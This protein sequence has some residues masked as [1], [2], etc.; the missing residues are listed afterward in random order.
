MTFDEVGEEVVLLPSIESFI[1]RRLQHAEVRLA[2]GALFDAMNLR[3]LA[4]CGF[5]ERATHRPRIVLMRVQI[6]AAQVFEPHAELVFVEGIDLRHVHALGG[7]T[8]RG[9][10]ELRIIP[11][12]HGIDHEHH[13]GMTLHIPLQAEEA[14]VRAALGDGLDLTRQVGERGELLLREDEKGFVFGEHRRRDEE[15]RMTDEL[16]V[17][18]LV[19]A[20]G[21]DVGTNDAA[22]QLRPRG[23]IRLRPQ[24]AVLDARAFAH[25]ST[26][27]NDIGATQSR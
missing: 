20:L 3:C 9:G 19:H 27:T 6:I 21:E 15:R 10:D 12:R 17:V 1:K 24:D 13:V 8:V 25:H 26:G 4:Q 22:P 16:E 11:A 5:I 23:D 2:Q 18:V 14:P 7:E